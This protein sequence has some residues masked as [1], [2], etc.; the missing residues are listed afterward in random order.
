[1]PTD[2]PPD[3]RPKSAPEPKKPGPPALPMP[4]G[5]D[6]RDPMGTPRPTPNAGTPGPKGDVVDP[7]GW[8]E[9]VGGPGEGLGVPTPAGTPSF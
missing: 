3:Y 6:A 4:Q 2:L 9:P 8:A 1:M 7:P 5:E